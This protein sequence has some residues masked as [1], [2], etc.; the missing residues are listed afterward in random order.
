MKITLRHKL[1]AAF[2]LLTLLVIIVTS[3]VYYYLLIKD[4][5]K[6]SRERIRVAMEMMLD[7]FLSQAKRVTPRIEGFINERLTMSMSL[8]YDRSKQLETLAAA[9]DAQYI[10]RLQG[11]IPIISS[12][13]SDVGKFLPVIGASEFVVYDTDRQIMAAYQKRRGQEVLGFYLHQ[14]HEGTFIPLRTNADVSAVWNWQELEDIPKNPLPEGIS[15]EYKGE[16]PTTTVTTLGT[17]G[18]TA[19][20]QL[21]VPILQGTE[22]QGVCVLHV[23]IQQSD[24]VRYSRFT[25]TQVNIFAGTSLSAGVLNDYITF[26]SPES[27]AFYNFD[28]FAEQENLPISYADIR[29][30]DQA[31]FQGSIIFGDDNAPSVVLTANVPRRIERERGQELLML[32]AGVAIVLGALTTIASLLLSS[33]IVRPIT[34][35]TALMQQ[36][37]RG[38]LT[39]ILE[40]Q[41]QHDVKLSE[42]KSW[43]AHDEVRLLTHSFYDMVGYLRAMSDVADNISRGEIRQTI[44]PRSEQ[45][46]LGHA[47][48]RMSEYIRNIAS[49]AT[50]IAD[51]DLRQDFQPQ[52]EYDVLGNAFHKM[53]ALRHAMRQIMQEA[54]HVRGASKNL[55]TISVHMASDTEAV[56]QKVAVVSDRGQQINQIVNGVAVAMEE[57]SANIREISRN[58]ADSANIVNAAVDIADSATTAIAELETHSQEID[59]ISKMI[60]TIT[61][62]TNLLALNATIEAAR[63][64]EAGKGFAVVA[65][66]VKTLAREI[67]LSAE[68]IIQRIAMI[69]SSS[70]KTA[71]AIDEV[72]NIMGQVNDFSNAIASSVEQQTM[73]VN[74]ITRSISDAAEGSNEVTHA[75]VDVATVTQNTSDQAADVQK[76]ANELTRL[77]D[78]LQELV[79]T[80]KI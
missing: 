66:E 72:S 9:Q 16:I 78:Q 42:K 5:R 15:P 35:I 62:Q 70:H 79:S 46:M 75:I 57:F 1:V 74:E 45:D 67:A 77:A 51:G 71:E 58:T 61:Q 31:Y 24:V 22:T 37:I 33:R 30:N 32:V 26:S 52:S 68:N 50:A 54:E 55:N 2:L 34:A 64:G 59:D 43:Q 18:E 49:V 17:L 38:D 20:L 27:E 10:A 60:T 19:T 63:A 69:Q 7:D 40:N 11:R 29:I 44:T 23:A 65:G 48:H 56:S 39:R 25:Q 8:I 41:S 13:I 21:T 53:G 28:E 14:L 76:A 3:G 6:V 4:L 12:M 73:A 47:F 36:I 80:F